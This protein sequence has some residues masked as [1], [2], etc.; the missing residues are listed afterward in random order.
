MIITFFFGKSSCN[1]NLFH[2]FSVLLP[3]TIYMGHVFL[4]HALVEQFSVKR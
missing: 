4:C 3:E 2:S 1:K